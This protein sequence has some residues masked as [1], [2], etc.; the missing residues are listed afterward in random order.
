MRSEV[1]RLASKY[2]RQD[3]LQSQPTIHCI[4]VY[5][6]ICDQSLS[7]QFALSHTP[8]HH[9]QVYIQVDPDADSELRSECEVQA[10]IH[11][12]PDVR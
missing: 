4:A 2:T 1:R 3:D 9:R 8:F 10:W 5:R 7:Q 6:R 11:G 12:I